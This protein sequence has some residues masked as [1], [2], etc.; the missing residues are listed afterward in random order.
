MDS[1]LRMAL[2]DG[3]A[4]KADQ[5]IVNGSDGLLNGTNLPNHNTAADDN[6]RRTTSQR[7]FPTVRVDGRYAVAD[8]GRALAGFGSRWD[9]RSHAGSV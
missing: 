7:N 6:L 5:E 4:E 2:N 9:L 8:H 1:A 3:L